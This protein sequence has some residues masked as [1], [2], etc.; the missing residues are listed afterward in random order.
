MSDDAKIREQIQMYEDVFRV[1]REKGERIPQEWVDGHR[2]LK[3]QLEGKKIPGGKFASL[4][5]FGH[6]EATNWKPSKYGHLIPI[7]L[8][9]K[10][11]FDAR[12]RSIQKSVDELSTKIFRARNLA[13]TGKGTEGKKAKAYLQSHEETEDSTILD[14]LKN[15]TLP[16]LRRLERVVHGV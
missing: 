16:E 11:D 8:D 3:A 6:P 7:V 4:Q 10:F 15:E 9:E 2:R 12:R 13:K 5:V 1:K 14:L